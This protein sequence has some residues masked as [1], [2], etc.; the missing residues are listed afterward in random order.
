MAVIK[1]L[2]P[3][4]DTS[5]VSILLRRFPHPPYV[6]DKWRGVSARILSIALFITFLLYVI[7]IAKD[8][9]EDKETKMRVHEINCSTARSMNSRSLMSATNVQLRRLHPSFSLPFSA[10][11]TPVPHLILEST[12]RLLWLVLPCVD[13]HKIAL[14]ASSSL[15]L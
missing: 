3:N 10:R 7:S 2:K 9:T 6:L 4:V 11:Q 5:R 1:V 13:C 12:S 8:V 15:R 14:D